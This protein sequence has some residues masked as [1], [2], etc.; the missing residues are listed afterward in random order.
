VYVGN[1]DEWKTAENQY[2]QRPWKIEGVPTIVHLKD[3]KE[4]GRLTERE[5]RDKERLGRF[6]EERERVWAET[7]EDIR[8]GPASG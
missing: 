1:R 4:T 7:G 3:G 2:R 5:I 8:R 6:V